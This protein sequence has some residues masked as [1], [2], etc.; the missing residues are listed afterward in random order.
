MEINFP[1]IDCMFIG[2]GKIPGALNK[3]SLDTFGRLSATAQKKRTGACLKLTWLVT[4]A[5]KNF[6][7][8][9]FEF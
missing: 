5:Y 1:N 3:N 9:I 7:I 8:T 2:H 6:D 4:F